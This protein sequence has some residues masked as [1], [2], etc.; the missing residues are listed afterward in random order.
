[1]GSPTGGGAPVKRGAGSIAALGSAPARAMREQ[2][3]RRRDAEA[4]LQLHLLQLHDNAVGQLPSH[5]GAA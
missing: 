1:M 3:R 4:K 5:P 2:A